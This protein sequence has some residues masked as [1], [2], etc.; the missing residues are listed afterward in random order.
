LGTCGA[1]LKWR[2]G[3]E[4]RDRFRVNRRNHEMGHDEP[5]VYLRWQGRRS[6][7][8]S[9]QTSALSACSRST[10]QSASEDS[11]GY[12]S[13]SVTFSCLPTA[14]A[15]FLRVSSVGDPAPLKSRDR[16]ARSMPVLALMFSNDRFCLSRSAL[17]AATIS[18]I[19]ASS[20]SSRWIRPADATKH[21]LASNG[22]R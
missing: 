14:F 10:E 9:F 19:C 15:S 17:I 18:A 8:R 22:S 11:A 3:S 4:R 21:Q 13:D 5:S 12:F 1:N 20:A 16:F 7:I 6:G 2:D